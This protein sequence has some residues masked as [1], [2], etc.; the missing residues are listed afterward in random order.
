MSTN[1]AVHAPKTE[2]TQDAPPMPPQSMALKNIATSRNERPSRKKWGRVL[3]RLPSLPSKRPISCK[4]KW[5]LKRCA[6][7]VFLIV[8][9]SP[10]THT[11]RF[12]FQLSSWWRLIERRRP[13]LREFVTVEETL[14]TTEHRNWSS[15]Q[16]IGWFCYSGKVMAAIFRD[17]KSNTDRQLG[18]G[19]NNNRV[20]SFVNVGELE[21]LVE[22]KRS[23]YWHAKMRPFIMATFRFTNPLSQW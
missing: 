22:A 23:R 20:W 9:C 6:R 5:A 2:R 4:K 7:D 21:R 17:Y 15:S 14:I 18:K 8:D 1:A 10:K 11:K 16:S 13:F 12:T 19:W 3:I